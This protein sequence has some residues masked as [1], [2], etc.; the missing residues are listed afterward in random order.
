MTAKKM[1]AARHQIRHAA[2][3]AVGADSVAV[4]DKEKPATI[5]TGA[6]HR[7]SARAQTTA[8]LSRTTVIAS[9]M[10]K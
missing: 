7:G 4:A 2:G 1:N 8:T 3:D 6:D 9:M 10:R 5:A